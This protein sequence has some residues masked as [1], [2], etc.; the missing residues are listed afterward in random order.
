M[1][2]HPSANP[3]AIATSTSTSGLGGSELCSAAIGQPPPA[4]QHRPQMGSSASSSLLNGASIANPLDSS[5]STSEA[6]SIASHPTPH[7]WRKSD[8]FLQANPWQLMGLMPQQGTA[9][10]QQCAALPPRGGFFGDPSAPLPMRYPGV[11]ENTAKDHVNST[12]YQV[13]PFQAHFSHCSTLF[14]FSPQWMVFIFQI[15][16]LFSL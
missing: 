8:E 12:F 3:F 15:F 9:M 4:H 7:D 6:A 2:N 13:C 1:L 16:G 5:I 14:L 11:E 10:Q